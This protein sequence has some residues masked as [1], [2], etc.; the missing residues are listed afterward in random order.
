MLHLRDKQCISKYGYF[1]SLRHPYSAK[2]VADVFVK[3]VVRLHG[4][5]ASIVSDRDSIFMS[6]FWKELF[7]LQGTRLNMST[8]YRMD[9]RKS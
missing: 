1:I 3:E 2:S 7:R 6:L 5:H 9:K 8:T 4:I